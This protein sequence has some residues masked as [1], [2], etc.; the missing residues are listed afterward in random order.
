MS[1]IGRQEQI[2]EHC[3][4]NLEQS[5]DHYQ[6][7]PTKRFTSP[8]NFDK[9]DVPAGP[10]DTGEQRIPEA[11]DTANLRA[12]MCR[13]DSI[14]RPIHPWFEDLVRTVGVVAGKGKYWNWGP[15]YTVDPIVIT[16]EDEPKILLVRRNDNGKWAFPGGFL[17]Y[18][19]ESV[20]KASLRECT[21]ETG[22]ILEDQP[23]KTVYVGP[24]ADERTTAH[25]WA[26]TNAKLWRP[27]NTQPITPQLDEVEA[28]KWHS[29]DKLPSNIHGSHAKIIEFALADL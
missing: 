24:V 25:A 28:V 2:R 27:K 1:M 15:N 16:D 3:L 8:E 6:G 5:S 26:Y 19:A 29:L 13:V 11:E 20:V 4:E 22:A 7:Y 14:G 9:F 17:D 12:K 18:A 23:E 21:E 10:W